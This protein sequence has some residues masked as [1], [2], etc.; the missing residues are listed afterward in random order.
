M[1]RSIFYGIMI[2]AL[3]GFSVLLVDGII[4]VKRIEQERTENV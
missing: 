1:K 2:V 4:Y 3:V